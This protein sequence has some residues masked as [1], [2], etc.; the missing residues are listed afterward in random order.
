MLTN[1]TDRQTRLIA[2]LAKAARAQRDAFLG[3]VAEASLGGAEP[4]RGEHNPTA[5]LGYDPLPPGSDPLTHLRA[6]I[7]SLTIAAR[8]ELYTLM[9]IGRGD[10]A[11]GTWRRGASEAQ[12]LG[13]TTVTAA[14]MDDADLHDHLEKGLYLSEAA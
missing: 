12:L 7:E 10:L 9:Q 2:L 13:D 4:A 8:A 14:L 5:E 3:N 6:A 1:V 11:A